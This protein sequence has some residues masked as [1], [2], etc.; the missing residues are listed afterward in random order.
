M[1]QT[2]L[3]PF[4]FLPAVVPRT[5]YESRSISFALKKHVTCPTRR[6]LH[7]DRGLRLP[8]V[9]VGSSYLTSALRPVDEPSSVLN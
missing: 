7:A 3:N 1:S 2:N 6:S 4:A 8:T 5:A 9:V